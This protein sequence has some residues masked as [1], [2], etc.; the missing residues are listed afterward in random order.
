MQAGR[1]GY[2]G[3]YNLTHSKRC[4]FSLPGKATQSICAYLLG[5]LKEILA[6]GIGGLFT[7]FNAC[8]MEYEVHSIGAE[9]I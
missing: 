2:M 6:Y 4:I 7:P 1:H 8:P 3:P 5:I 9:P